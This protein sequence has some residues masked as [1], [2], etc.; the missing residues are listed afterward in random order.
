MNETGTPYFF[1]QM[2]NNGVFR[3]FRQRHFVET[4]TDLLTLIQSRQRRQAFISA[5]VKIREA[6]GPQRITFIACSS[7]KLRSAAPAKDL[8]TGQLFRKAR[9]LAEKTSDQYYILSALHGLLQP[10]KVTAPYNYTLKTLSKRE[11]GGWG[12]RILKDSLWLIPKGSTITLLAGNDYCDPIEGKLG[13]NG[14]H[15]T[16]PLKG[17]PIGKQ[18]QQ[19]IRLLAAFSQP[20]AENS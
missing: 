1:H 4:P 6:R 14:F 11:R 3:Y 19:L 16:R 2:S 17:L 10:D 8:Y 15:V 13:R 12:D 9:A 5:H 18:Q 20:A 7:A